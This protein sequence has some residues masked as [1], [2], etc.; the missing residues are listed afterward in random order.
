[1]DGDL[2]ALMIATMRNDL[3]L[4]QYLVE[5]GWR[6]T[7]SS[8]PDVSQEEVVSSMLKYHLVSPGAGRG[9]AGASCSLQ[10]VHGKRALDLA[11]ELGFEEVHGFLSQHTPLPVVEEPEEPKVEDPVSPEEDS[12]VPPPEVDEA[13]PP[14]P[15]QRKASP[16][17]PPPPPPPPKAVSRC[18]Y[19]CVL[20]L[21]LFGSLQRFV[22]KRPGLVFLSWRAE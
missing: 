14:S 11:E 22:Q 8:S 16:P 17:P 21:S 3:P 5:K 18:V 13:R 12:P 1:M 6:F 15:P 20:S 9:C 19:V 2:T 10:N 7:L 4:V